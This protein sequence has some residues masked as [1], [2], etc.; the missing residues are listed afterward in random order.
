MFITNA[1]LASVFLVVATLDYLRAL[2]GLAT[3]IVE[4]RSSSVTVGK[5]IEKDRYASF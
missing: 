4:K 5:K 3:F 1:S 2:K